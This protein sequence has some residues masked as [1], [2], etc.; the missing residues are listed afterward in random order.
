MAIKRQVNFLGTMRVDVPHLRLMESAVA[1]DFQALSGTFMSG[2]TALVAAGVHILDTGMVGQP[3]STLVLRMA[4]AALLHGTATEPGAIFTVPSNQPDDVLS[5]ANAAVVGSFTPGVTNYI[6]LDLI[7]TADATTQDTVIFRSVATKL[8]FPQVAPLGRVLNYTINI[9]TS[10]F[11]ATPT[12]CPVAK[13]ITDANNNIVSITD[14]R[15]MFFRLG[16]GGT[17]PDPLAQYAWANRN[18]TTSTS[19]FTGGDKDIASQFSF[20]G[21]VLQRLWELGGGEHWY[22]PA[23]DRS[24]KLVYTT[25]SPWGWDGTDITWTGLK[26]T[27][28]NSTAETNTVTDQPAAGGA[29]LQPSGYPN[30]TTMLD[31]DVI[32]VDLDRT[33]NATITAHRA[34]RSWL[35]ANP[36]ALPGTRHILA[37]RVG[38]QVFAGTEGNDVTVTVPLPIATNVI[39]GGV[40]LNYASSTPATPHV[41]VINASGYA[42]A[43]GLDRS[44]PGALSIGVSI[45]TSLTFA[46]AGVTSTFMGAVAGQQGASFTQ[47]VV[48]SHGGTFSGNGTGSGVYG[49]GGATGL[50]GVYGACGT[51][52]SYG[53]EGD[54]TTATTNGGGVYGVGK[55]TGHGVYGAGGSSVNSYGVYGTIGAGSGAFAIYGNGSTAT[56]NGTGVRGLGK[57]TGHGVSGTGGSDPAAYGVY[58]QGN[59]AAGS[60]A[61]VYGIGGAGG[62]VGVQGLGVGTYPGMQAAPGANSAAINLVPR[63]GVPSTVADGD[64]WY[65][66][67]TKQFEGHIN[68]EPFVFGPTGWTNFDTS[69]GG[70][71]VTYRAEGT[72]ANGT[73]AVAG[74]DLTFTFTVARR[75]ATY[76]VMAQG[77]TGAGG[78]PLA[79]VVKSRA[80]GS[81]VLENYL[82]T[83]GAGVGAKRNWVDGSLMTVVLF[84]T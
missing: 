28:G 38:A 16:S 73:W 46:K 30:L 44:D 71:G 29:V 78:N 26:F 19:L 14:C 80:V 25:A 24:V 67:T 63:A 1:A 41:P 39:N 23:D 43:T 56:T 45:A 27:F 10:N 55:G 79:I 59:A 65:N 48:D 12:L 77:A 68:A 74:T 21:A 11:G 50:A 76:C 51:G 3:S 66:S 15:Q 64:V 54:G 57:G 60:G 72:L 2:N 47:S 37:W 52:G 40:I 32:Y 58:G 34:H 9:S 4:N 75:D 22:S 62:G 6:A 18:E 33:T 13:V 36:P 7:R 69:G 84:G 5:T 70:M 31:G 42:V 83:P 61:G 17:S 82:L 81:F 53:V 20:N 35:F 8:E 49:T